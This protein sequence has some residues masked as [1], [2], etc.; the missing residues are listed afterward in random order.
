MLTLI[1]IRNYAIIDDLEIEL[2][3]G[4]S[5][6]TGE[7]GAGKSILVDALGL[8]LG[9]RADVSTIRRGADRAEISLV[10]ELEDRDLAHAWLAEHGLDD[11]GI[12]TLRRAISSEGGSRAFIN[13][14]PVSLKDLRAAGELLVDIH[15]QHEHHSLLAAPVQRQM[16]DS[17]GG[18]L[19]LAR[20]VAEAHACWQSALDE[21]AQRNHRTSD[22]DAALDLLRF[23][24][25]EV[26]ELNLAEGEPEA[27]GIEARRLRNVDQLQAAVG[28]AA[29]CVYDSEAETSYA[30]TSRARRALESGMRHDP[31]LASLHE[32]IAALEIELQELGGELLRRI[33][34][35]DANP[36][37]LDEIESR[38]ARV[39]QIARRHRI[40]EESV[41][42][43]AA[44]LRAEIEELDASAASLAQAD[45]RCAAERHRYETLAQKLS[46]ARR[47]AAAPLGRA[48][49]AKL[50]EL[51]L[52]AA[53][54]S[55]HIEPKPEA[56]HDS[57]GVDVVEF[58]VTM[59]PGEPASPI[60]RVASGGELSRIGLA[61][62]VVAHDATPAPTLVF[63]EIDAGIGGAVAEVVGRRLREIAARNQ[64][65]CVTHLPQVA[66]QGTRHYRIAK[67]TDCGSSR[68][69]VRL[70]DGEQRVEE[71]SRMLGGLEITATTRAH[72]AEMIRQAAAG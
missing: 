9:D 28:E 61:L 42:G 17:S 51:G 49:T 53:A 16:L 50:R 2:H 23:Q 19:D 40:P 60:Q 56:R 62:A 59:N 31:D 27:L 35:L 32:R 20:T 25:Q 65:L 22:R 21:L 67:S 64:V 8:A 52:P 54:F 4:F 6:M 7:T 34:H 36:A 18:H 11:Q 13:N 44:R 55:V 26:E 3:A 10:F 39:Q 33:D 14:Q 15:G 72:A 37:R 70:L 48:V 46:Q 29:Q 57:T 45:A 69:Q 63:D 12:C 43:L 24:L 30:L 5:V 68:T 71:L 58:R 41:P 1:R 66:S 38:L 47:T